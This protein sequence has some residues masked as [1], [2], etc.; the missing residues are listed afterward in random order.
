MKQ[1]ANSYLPEASVAFFT[2]FACWFQPAQTSQPIVFSSHNKPAPASP[3]Q[4]RNRPANSPLVSWAVG[5]P[6]SIIACILVSHRF[7]TSNAEHP[8]VVHQRMNAVMPSCGC[9]PGRP[10]HAEIAALALHPKIRSSIRNRS[11]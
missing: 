2:L 4:L 1:P 9:V 5:K 6:N 10:L 7:R 3:N 11:Q 8:A